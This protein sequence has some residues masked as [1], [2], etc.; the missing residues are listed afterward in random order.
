MV[1]AYALDSVLNLKTR[2]GLMGVILF[3]LLAKIS[4][5]RPLENY[6]NNKKL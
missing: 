3:G 5:I 2:I 4:G 1:V 6:N